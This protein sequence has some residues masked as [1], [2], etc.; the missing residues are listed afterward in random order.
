[1]ANRTQGDLYSDW[2]MEPITASLYLLFLAARM[3]GTRQ[4]VTNSP[5]YQSFLYRSLGSDVTPDPCYRHFKLATAVFTT[6]IPAQ[7]ENVELDT[8]LNLRRDLTDGR[9]R[10]QD[11]VESFSKDLQNATC[12]EE[13]IGAL[14]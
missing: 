2:E 5:S 14:P 10:F 9:R 7:I 8:L 4:L 11:K 6:A 1:L 13:F 3:A 12:E